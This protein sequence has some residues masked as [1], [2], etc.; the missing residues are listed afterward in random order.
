MPEITTRSGH[1]ITSSNHPQYLQRV[2]RRADA[3]S[4]QHG[5][6]AAVAEFDAKAAAFANPPPLVALTMLERSNLLLRNVEKW[7]RDF[8]QWQAARWNA[9]ASEPSDEFWDKVGW[10]DDE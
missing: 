6:A 8:R 2:L 1:L 5:I 4:S 9:Q 10:I 7:E 3:L